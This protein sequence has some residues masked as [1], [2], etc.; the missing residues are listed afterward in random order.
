[1]VNLVGSGDRSC[2]N[3]ALPITG[4]GNMGKEL[5]ISESQFPDP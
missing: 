1:M 3:P 4:S 2:L 5:N